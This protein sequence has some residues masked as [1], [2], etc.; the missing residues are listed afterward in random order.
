MA[1]VGWLASRAVLSTLISPVSACPDLLYTL[2]KT[3]KSCLGVV[4]V[5]TTTKKSPLA[6]LALAES[7]WLLPSVEPRFT[8]ISGP[9]V[10]S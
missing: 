2:T 3:S 9:S 7:N 5:Q 4:L 6:E 8:V 1:T 10:M